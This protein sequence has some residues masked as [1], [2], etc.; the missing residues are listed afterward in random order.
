[1]ML[2]TVNVII[3]TLIDDVMTFIDQVTIDYCTMAIMGY[4]ANKVLVINKH[5]YLFQMKSERER[6]RVREE[7]KKEKKQQ[8]KD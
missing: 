2:W 4:M 1:M 5:L 8:I 3:F 7:T 6:E